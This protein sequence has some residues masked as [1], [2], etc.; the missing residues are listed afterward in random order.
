[1]GYPAAPASMVLLLL[2]VSLLEPL[3]EAGGQQTGAALS[4]PIHRPQC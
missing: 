3:R 1:M 2:L 4:S